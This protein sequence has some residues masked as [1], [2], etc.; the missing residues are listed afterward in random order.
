MMTHTVHI[1]QAHIP[2]GAH[3][4]SD[5]TPTVFFLS[6]TSHLICCLVVNCD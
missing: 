6:L 2:R 3:K 1:I 4:L 5:V